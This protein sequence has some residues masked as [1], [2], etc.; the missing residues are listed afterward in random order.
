MQKQIQER[1]AVVHLGWITLPLSS[2]FDWLTLE[3]FHIHDSMRIIISKIASF[4][5]IVSQSASIG[6]TDRREYIDRTEGYC[7]CSGM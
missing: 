3:T 6:K 5:I 7:V 2:K 1:T 4:F